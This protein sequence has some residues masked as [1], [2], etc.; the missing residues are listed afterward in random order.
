MQLASLHIPTLKKKAKAKKPSVATTPSHYEYTANP[1]TL[2]GQGCTDGAAK[3]NWLMTQHPRGLR[4]S[5]ARHV[6]RG[7]LAAANVPSFPLA[8]VTNITSR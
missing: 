1:A 5:T 8:A 7:A 2:Y 3:V 4:S 6:L